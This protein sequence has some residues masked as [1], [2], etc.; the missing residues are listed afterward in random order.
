FPIPTGGC[1]IP[2]TA[3]AYSVN[4]TVV[5]DGMLSYLTTWPAG[6]SQPGVSTLNSWDGAVVANA[7][8]VP[9]GTSGA[10]SVYVTNP[11]HVILDVNGYFAP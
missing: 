4:V 5:P 11:T 9:A 8:L 1:G 7:A 2:P 3:A 6:A 10:I